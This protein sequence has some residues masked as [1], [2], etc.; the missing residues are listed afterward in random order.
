M[1][2]WDDAA[3][4]H[5]GW[6]ALRGKGEGLHLIQRDCLLYKFRQLMG[7]GGHGIGPPHGCRILQGLSVTPQR[8]LVPLWC[9]ILWSLVRHAVVKQSFNRSNFIAH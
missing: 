5:R 9:S 8:C 3:S 7:A 4:S 1:V 2:L 6:S